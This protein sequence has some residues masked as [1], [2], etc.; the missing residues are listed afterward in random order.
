MINTLAEN[1][2]NTATKKLLQLIQDIVSEVHPQRSASLSITLDSTFETD[3]GLDSLARVELISRVEK[4]FKL[5]LP[6]QVFAEVETVRDLLDALHGAP[7][8]QS[9]L[10]MTE[11]PTVEMGKIS[12]LPDEAQ[13]LIDVL[14]WHLAH[15]PDRHHIQMYQDEGNGETLTYRQLKAGAIKVAG[16]LQQLGLEP[17]GPVSIMLPSGPDYF[18]SFFG[19]LM[20]GGIPVPIYPPVRLSQ[21]EDHMRR[22]SR[23]LSNC[24]ASILITVTEA[25]GVAQLLKSQVP[26][27]QHIV[28]VSKLSKSDQVPSLPTLNKDDIAFIQYTSGSTGNPKGVVLTHANLLSNIRAMGQAIEVNSEDIFIS[29]LPLYHDMGLIGAWLGSM[30]FALLFV[31]MSPLSFLARPERWLWAI[32]RYRGT[33]SASPN[34]GYEYCLKRINEED[35]KGLDL[36]SWRAAF[37]GA[38]AVSPDTL[39]EF[40]QHFARFGFNDNA[41]MPVYGLAESSVGLAFPPVGRGPLIDHIDRITFMDT[42]EAKPVEDEDKNALRFPSC[43]VALARHQLRVV[44]PTGHELTERQ[45]GQLQFR[46][47][48]ST[49]GY[50]RDTEKTQSLFDGD[51]IN[52]G[53]LAYIANGEIYLTGRTKDIIIRAGRNIYPDELEQAVGNVPGIRKGR[54]VVFG[55]KDERSGTERL[56]I[57]TETREKDHAEREKLHSQISKL[58]TD[59]TGTPPDQIILAPPGTVL[60]TSS[61]K[62]RRSASREIFEKGEIGKTQRGAAWQV[63][64]LLFASIIPQLRRAIGTVSDVLFATYCW[65]IFA[66]LVPVVWLSVVLLPNYSRRWAVTRT[67]IRLLAKMTATHISIN[68]TENLPAKGQPYVM[69]ANHASYLDS[70]ALLAM[71][72]R[73]FR[74]VAKKEFTEN[75]FWRQPLKNLHTEFVERFDIGKSVSDVQHLSKVLKADDPLLFFAEG[76]FTNVPGLMPF[77]LGPFT[78]AAETSTPVVP[79]A[80]KGTRSMLRGDSKFPYRGSINIEIGEQIDPSEIMKEPD[81][82]NW[83]IAISLRNRSRD[84]I[85]QHCSEPDLK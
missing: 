39:Q 18:F 72:P 48:S 3:L 56:I 53:D 41:M 50:Y 62:I 7:E 52:S 68:G 36:S 67:C 73:H 82:S 1:Q 38:E 74:F 70:Y 21:L 5:A 23:I 20:A 26:K 43:G 85:L 54:V 11:M 46:G 60:K 57:L 79:L 15:H 83:H 76:T 34:F 55:S 6:E 29:W 19:I 28:T 84:F 30:Y 14:D 25:R 37:N 51:W 69:V 49:S 33:L 80:I 63:I 65:V 44:D 16:G 4:E 77:H 27:L 61:G 24:G 75:F 10:S 45:Q 13:T 58:A 17:A 9:K 42:G 59:L 8:L 12:T 32:H 2:S 31:V 81:S 64:R 47:P 35:L 71:L 40:I 22:H 78:V 66:A